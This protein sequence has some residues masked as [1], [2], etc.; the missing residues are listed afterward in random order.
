M[1]KVLKVE[2]H[3]ITMLKVSLLSMYKVTLLTVIWSR[4]LDMHSNYI[5]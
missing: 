4:D 2:C 3:I 1:L 5:G